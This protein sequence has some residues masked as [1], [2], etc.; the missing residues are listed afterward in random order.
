MVFLNIHS[1]HIMQILTPLIQGSWILFTTMLVHFSSAMYLREKE[2]IQMNST[3][4]FASI[5]IQINTSSSPN[6]STIGDLDCALFNNLCPSD[7]IY[8][9]KSS[10]IWCCSQD[11]DC[12]TRPY[13]CR[14][15]DTPPTR[16]NQT[17]HTPL[18]PSSSNDTSNN[19]PHHHR[20]RRRRR[21]H[22]RRHRHRHHH[23]DKTMV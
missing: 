16:V 8:C 14:I 9:C 2:A 3:S 5:N 4:S 1:S 12:G 6:A 10:S 13:T 20:K 23:H 22:R 17:S 21:R 7:T 18:Q 15:V 19:T 11:E